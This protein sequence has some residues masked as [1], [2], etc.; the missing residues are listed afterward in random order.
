[1]KNRSKIEEV[2]FYLDRSQECCI[3]VL[4]SILTNPRLPEQDKFEC[5][6]L[7]AEHHQMVGSFVAQQLDDGERKGYALAGVTPPTA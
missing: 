6:R 1:L 2:Q 3:A 4:R 7:I 5:L